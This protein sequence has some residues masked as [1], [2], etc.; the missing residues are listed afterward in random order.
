MKKIGQSVIAVT[1]TL[2]VWAAIGIIWHGTV[3]FADIFGDTGG[4]N[5][6]LLI[7]GDL[8]ACAGCFVCLDRA[9]TTRVFYT[10]RCVSPALR[11]ILLSRLRYNEVTIASIVR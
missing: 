5:M 11:A 7:G 3:L 10:I 4:E 6:A 2:T 1:V 8:V 9:A